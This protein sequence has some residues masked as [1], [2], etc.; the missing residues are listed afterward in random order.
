MGISERKERNKKEM[1]ENILIAAR[2]LFIRDGYENV[3][4]RKIAEEIEYS[5][6]TIY[7]YFKDKDEIFYQLY[8]DAFDQFYK[9]QLEAQIIEEPVERLRVHGEKYLKFAIENPEY[10]DLM[11]IS[12]VPMKPFECGEKTDPPGRK[13]FDLLLQNIRDCQDKGL[14]KDIPEHAAALYVWSSVHGLA[15][16]YLKKR[17]IQFP[18]E[19]R[20]VLVNEAMK[21]IIK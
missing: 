1:R 7:L 8:S 9:Y 13:T 5:P 2:T 6:T 3:S 18:E 21:L 11:F 16:L 15:T 17:L 14:F 10:Y 4:I 12:V 20:N 19:I